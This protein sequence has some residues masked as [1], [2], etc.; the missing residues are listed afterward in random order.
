MAAEKTHVNVAVC[1]TRRMSEGKAS[2]IL[3]LSRG[4]AFSAVN[5]TN[6]THYAY[7]IQR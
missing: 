7:F 3:I 4:K 6:E 2:L 1:P 5:A